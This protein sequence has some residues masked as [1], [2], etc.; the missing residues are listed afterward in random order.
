[1]IIL[2]WFKNALL[3]ILKEIASFLIKIVMVMVIIIILLA[4]FVPKTSVEK[5]PIKKN[6]YIELE[7]SKPIGER[8]S[9]SIFTIEGERVNF[10]NMLNYLDKG[11]NDQRIDGLILKVDSVALNRAQVDELGRK[12]KEYREAG[13]KV[14]A[15]SR[16]FENRNYSLAV[17]ADEI[18][19]PPSRGA[20]SNIS[21]YFMELP[22][23]KRLSE[24]IGIKYDVIHVGEYKSYGENYVR[25]GMS[26][27]F[28]E[29]ITRLLD[30]IYY[31]F[32]QDVSVARNID[33]RD[34]SK[35]ILNGDFVLADA[36][37]MKQ[38]KLVDTLMYYHEFLKERNIVNTTT[39]GKYSRSV[40]GHQGS[41]KK[42]A[43]IYGDG[44]ILYTNS[45]RSA[46]QAITPDTMISELDI[47]TRD[48]EVAGIVLRIDSP[49]GSA[50]AS[51]VINA[52]IRSIEKPVYVS[53][54]GT[55]ASGG[56]YISASGDRVFAERDTVTGSIGVVSLVPDVSELAGK[57]GIKMESVQ[58]GRLSGIYSITDGMTK[59]EKD[60]I[61]ESSFKI[62]S[63]F[64]ERVSSGRNIPMNQLESI[65]GGRVW[66]GEEALE[67]GL[68]DG[69]GG[70]QDTI[71]L[72]AKDLQ[73]SE[74]SV[75]E[76]RK[77]NPFE[78]LFMNY[79]YL[80]NFYSRFNSLINLE[81][82][83]DEE[84]LDNELLI[85]PVTYLPYKI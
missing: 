58:K 66:L 1:M 45:G 33:E 3:F 39:L 64:K 35:K 11:K 34:L 9:F 51:E 40:V 41:G 49:G 14:Y 23:M 71:R 75:V 25:E 57:L 47:A 44:E 55:S 67:K 48:K 76:I 61:Y 20:G 59:E 65:A 63:E 15:F 26:Q 72:M 73:I 22:Y 81:I 69:I 42:I 2:K 17:N 30:R 53:M 28:R 21:G 46:Q 31:N 7:L 78:K 37:K 56:Y 74:Y 5:A 24:K 10:Y 38:E 12:I 85:K 80:E 36:F 62:Y 54:G 13:K 77:E 29:N 4:V 32:V 83:N 18:I 43:L 70:L 27:E 60:R 16:G 84:M 79:K 52:K 68:V 6:T 19:M 82:N 50:L 8:G